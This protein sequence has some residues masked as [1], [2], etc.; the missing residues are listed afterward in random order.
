MTTTA[1]TPVRIG[2]SVGADRHKLV[3]GFK[4]HIEGTR[5]E[6]VRVEASDVELVAV[7]HVRPRVLH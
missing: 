3:E 2:A 1:T 5:L 4:Q 7:L 6:I